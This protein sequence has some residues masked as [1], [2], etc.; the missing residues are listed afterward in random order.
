MLERGGLPWPR[1]DGLHLDVAGTIYPTGHE[2]DDCHGVDSTAAGADLVHVV[3]TDSA[4]MEFSMLPNDVGNFYLTST[5]TFPLH[6]KVMNSHGGER[7]MVGTVH[8]G[9]CNH[10]H[11]QSG[12]NSAPGRITVPQ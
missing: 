1:D 7:A 9:N 5:L 2:P 8:D 11:T 6:A 3:V 4:G 10:C 12:D